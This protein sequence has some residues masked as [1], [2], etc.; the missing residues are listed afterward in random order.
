MPKHCAE[1]A[2]PALGS[3]ALHLPPSMF[4]RTLFSEIGNITYIGRGGGGQAAGVCCD[5]MSWRQAAKIW[6]DLIRRSRAAEI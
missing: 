6:G 4:V 2:T 3:V 1:A 5:L